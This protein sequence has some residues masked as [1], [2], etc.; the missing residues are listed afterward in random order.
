MRKAT[1]Q[2]ILERTEWKVKVK[3]Q[4]KR[5][6]NKWFTYVGLNK[7]D[8]F[9]KAKEDFFEKHQYEGIINEE[10][11]EWCYV[12]DQ[13]V[14]FFWDWKQLPDEKFFNQL[15]SQLKGSGK[16]VVHVP[17]D[18]DAYLWFIGDKN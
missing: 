6:K 4:S 5:K 13:S 1:Q 16:E 3:S 14:L 8:A 11:S 12:E 18:G 15:D 2:E 9:K 7:E 10:D 17:F